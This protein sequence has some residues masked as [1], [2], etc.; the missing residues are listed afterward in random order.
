MEHPAFLTKHVHLGAASVWRLP[1][2]VRLMA[3]DVCELHFVHQTQFGMKA[4]KPTFF[5]GWRLRSFKQNLHLYTA[6]V[7]PHEIAALAG[8]NDDGSFKTA[9]GKEYPPALCKAIACSFC[10]FG[11]SAESSAIAPPP[12]APTVDFHSLVRPFI[13]A[14]SESPEAF[15]AD[16]VDGGELALLQLPQLPKL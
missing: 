11:V 5:A 8:R 15:G 12:H 2:L 1:E 4:H 10:D 14:V 6:P 16:F 9:V 3:L 7:S 13:I